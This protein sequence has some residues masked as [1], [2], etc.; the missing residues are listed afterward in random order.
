M[1]RRQ[2]L[3]ALLFTSSSNQARSPFLRL[4]AELRNI[5]YDYYFEDT[6]WLIPGKD[7]FELSIYTPSL[8]LVCRQMHFDTALIPYT[9]KVIGSANDVTPLD[10]WIAS[11]S[12]AQMQ[13]V[14][15]LELQCELVLSPSGLAQWIIPV[16]RDGRTLCLFANL[17]TVYAHFRLSDRGRRDGTP[18]LPYST[19]ELDRLKGCWERCVPGVEIIMTCEE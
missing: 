14:T 7:D 8:F 16:K 11:K 13:A 4:S 19:K 9:Q 1:S 5:I 15:C 2:R 3:D 17:K 18:Y 6:T 12:V 10:H